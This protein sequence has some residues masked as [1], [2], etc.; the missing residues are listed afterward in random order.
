MRNLRREAWLASGLTLLLGFVSFGMESGME[1]GNETPGQIQSPVLASAQN[2]V[3][4]AGLNRPVTEA[5]AT[6]LS[7][8]K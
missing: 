6:R 2:Q 4:Q 1:S 3:T 7:A 8:G 5:P